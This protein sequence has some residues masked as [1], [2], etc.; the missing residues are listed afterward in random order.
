MITMFITYDLVCKEYEKESQELLTILRNSNSRY[1][2]MDINKIYWTYSFSYVR[3]K[4][5]NTPEY[6]EN[7]FKMPFEERFEVELKKVRVNISLT[8][9]YFYITDR[10][11]NISESIKETV[12]AITMQKMVNEQEFIGD[13]GVLNSIPYVVEN[14]KPKPM[15]LQEQLQHAI[16]VEDYMEAARIRDMIKK[17]DEV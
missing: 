14:D 2:D 8:A 4:S 3:K 9:G 15:S 13:E 6:Y 1:K 10:V 16:D 11:S 7:L 5:E 12:K 17:Q